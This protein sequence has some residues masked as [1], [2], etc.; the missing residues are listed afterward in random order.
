MSSETNLC[1]EYLTTEQILLNRTDLIIKY[2]ISVIFSFNVHHQ[3]YK[4]SFFIMQQKN[5][6]GFIGKIVF[7]QAK[8]L[9]RC[10][11]FHITLSFNLWED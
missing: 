5:H 2:W 1:S 4:V 7:S 8:Q 6:P 9:E 10:Y 11:K 3:N